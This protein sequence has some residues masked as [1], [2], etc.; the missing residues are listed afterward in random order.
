[1]RG[2]SGPAFPSCVGNSLSAGQSAA[3]A[4]VEAALN[5]ARN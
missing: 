1:M 4:Q 5:A 3:A 2:E